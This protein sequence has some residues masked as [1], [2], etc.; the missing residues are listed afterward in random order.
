MQLMSAAWSSPA[1]ATVANALPKLL[2]LPEK[3]GFRYAT[4]LK[5][6]AVPEWKVAHL[7]KHPVG[8]PSHKPKKFY[9]SFHYQARA[10]DQARRVVAKVEWHEGELAPRVGFIV[11]NLKLFAAIPER[12]GRLRV[13]CA[14][15]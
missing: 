6:N 4:R 15:G 13:A 3:E 10:W 14:S 9:A 7:L 5:G 11:T 1:A 12:I 2:R 8:P